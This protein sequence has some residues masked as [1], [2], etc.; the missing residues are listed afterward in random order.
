[1]GLISS[2]NET[3]AKV[4]TLGENSAAIGGIVNV[5]KN[6][7]EQTNLLAL[8]AAIEAARAGEQGRGFAVVADEVRSLAN[9]TQASAQEIEGFIELLLTNVSL[10]GESIKISMKLASESDELFEGVV[11]SYSEIVG[12]MQQVNELSEELATSIVHEQQSAARVFEKLKS[13]TNITDNSVE[14]VEQLNGSSNELKSLGYQLI[15]T[16]ASGQSA[17]SGNA[18]VDMSNT[19]QNELF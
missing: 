18:A 19:D 16:L 5:I 13:I 10:A 9:K 8:N 12:Y 1:M 11:M 15:G 4:D 17:Q 2:V 6:V 14:H 7:A 3:G